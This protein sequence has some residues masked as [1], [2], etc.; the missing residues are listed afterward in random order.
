MLCEAFTFDV[1]VLTE[2]LENRLWNSYA[3]MILRLDGI[4]EDLGSWASFCPCHRTF[5]AGMSLHQ[6]CQV[7]QQHFGTS[8]F[9][10]PLAGCN[11]PEFAAGEVL[12]ILRELW[13]SH[14]PPLFMETAELALSSEEMS[15]LQGDLELC[16][17]R[18]TLT[19]QTKLDYFQRLP[20]LLAGCAALDEDV[21]RCLAKKAL[22]LYDQSP[23]AALQH[24]RSHQLLQQ[25]SAFREG[26]VQF[27]AGAA[28]SSLSHAKVAQANRTHS[29]GPV[30]VSLQ[31]RMPMLERRLRADQEDRLPSLQCCKKKNQTQEWRGPRSD[32]SNPA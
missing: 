28:R 22:A 17:S 1:T 16:R 13:A 10:C 23:N 20:W 2:T 31:N 27:A 24:P 14:V 26:L 12:V 3:H 5:C 8:R 9:T 29:L 32:F 30:K 15:I 4:I 11:A 25:G 7:M 18:M 6:R 21:A 19:L